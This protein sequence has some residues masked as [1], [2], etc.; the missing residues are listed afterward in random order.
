MRLRLSTLLMLFL[1]AIIQS[2]QSAGADSAKMASSEENEAKHPGLAL[3]E[4]QCYSCHHP[5][6]PH[7]SRL[8]PPMIAVKEHYMRD[9]PSQQEFTNAMLEFLKQPT[10]DK[11]KMPGAVRRFGLMPKMAFNESDIIK[12]SEYL[13]TE[14][15]LAPDWYA[16][17]KKEKHGEGH[18]HGK[19]KGHQHGKKK[20]T[21]AEDVSDVERGKLM[22]LAT[23]AT[24][25]KN[26]MA[27]LQNKGTDG[28]LAFCNERAYP[29][30]DSV[31]QL[32]N[33]RIK[34]VSD[35]NRN[36]QNA[37]NADELAYIQQ[38]KEQLANGEEIAPF[39]VADGLKRGF[40]PILTNQMCMQC[41]G[42]PQTDIAPSTMALISDLYP[43][44]KAIG[45]GVN[46]LRGIW[47]VEW[48]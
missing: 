4:T 19:G 2:C 12:I 40:Y 11:S 47:V 1:F 10:K 29:L 17:H 42:Q 8:A 9:E 3:M 16:D 18:G 27:A 28:A 31:A 6:A 22:A 48:E 20:S 21:S 14:E 41:H 5:D 23:K 35:K 24:L 45:Y 15:V 25:G 44:D 33:A 43:S 13:Y 26:L 36:P 34:R 30:T 32:K 39:F 37:A 7:D 38:A 46:E